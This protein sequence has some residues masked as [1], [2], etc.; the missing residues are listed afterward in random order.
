MK[1]RLGQSGGPD[2]GVTEGGDRSLPQPSSTDLPIP[3]IIEEADQKIGEDR[4]DNANALTP[5]V[6]RNR[7][8]ST[9][10]P[11]SGIRR[12]ASNSQRIL[13]VLTI[14]QQVGSRAIAGALHHDTNSETSFLVFTCLS[15]Q[16]I[17]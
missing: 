11:G 16:M 6:T 5:P 3:T 10:S 7:A 8:S 13:D 2:E 4:R 12:P 1:S 17:A 14:A 9:S 15:Q